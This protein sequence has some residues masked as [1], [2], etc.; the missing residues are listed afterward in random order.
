MTA[1]IDRRYVRFGRGSEFGDQGLRRRRHLGPGDLETVVVA[2]I[3]VGD[4]LTLAAGDVVEQ[5]AEL[6][7]RIV[8][9][10]AAQVFQVLVV[11]GDHMGEAAKVRLR[12]LPRLQPR[13]LDP[14]PP[15]RRLRPRVR[16][17][18]RMPV[19]GSGGID[20]QVETEPFRLGAQGGLGERGATDVAE[21]DEEDGGHV[22]E[23]LYQSRSRALEN[24]SRK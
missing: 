17:L 1:A 11:Q 2:E 22:W 24:M 5:Q 7:G 18:A 20:D 15:R 12:H 13:N 6:G 8:G 19:P 23:C 3:G 14:M 4:G 16:R 10:Q 9:P 21:A